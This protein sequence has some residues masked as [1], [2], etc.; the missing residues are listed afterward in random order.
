M[1]RLELETSTS[2][3][4][5]QLKAWLGAYWL[6]VLFVIVSL[7][8]A[9]FPVARELAGF[10]N[11]FDYS[12]WYS[13]GSQVL[14]GGDLYPSSPGAWFAFI[15]P[16]FAAV[17]LAPL[18]LYGY[19]PSMLGVSLVYAASFCV[20]IGLSDR[21]AGEAR[22][23]PWW[24]VALPP[25]LA[26]PVIAENFNFGQPNLMLLAM[27]LVGLALLSAGRQGSAGAMFALATALKAFPVAILPYLLWRR[28]WRAAASM[29]ALTAVFLLLVPAPFRGFERNLDETRTWFN[30]MVVSADADGFGQRP[31]LSWSLKNGSLIAVTHRLLRP[32]NAEALDPTAKP[33]DVNIVDLSYRQAN[34]VVIVIAALIGFGFIAALPP[35]PR[36][37]PKS[38][39][40]E[41]GVLLALMTVASPLARDYYFVWL[42]PGVTVLVYRAAMA[43]AAKARAITWGLLAFAMALF[44]LRAPHPPHWPQAY[45]SDLWGT[46]VIVGA[47][48]WHMRRDAGADPS[49]RLTDAATPRRQP[50][51]D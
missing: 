18:C 1:A 34:L 50:A 4:A 49:P 48:V 32:L 17:L 5:R 29:V 37:T 16:P 46:A 9:A 39:G 40:A 20:S 38:D 33:Y 13:A 43:P 25:I 26:L 47:L 31:E 15:Y 11:K 12:L 22:P 23:R 24:V 27:M 51:A 7:E 36:R 21:L 2:P 8:L 41:Y 14:S 28:R 30:A 6:P 42:L 3:P 44:A 10:H 45:G 35:E 19:L